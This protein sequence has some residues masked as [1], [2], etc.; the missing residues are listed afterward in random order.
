MEEIG[1]GSLRCWCVGS[2][3][4]V[5]WVLVQLACSAQQ[6][7]DVPRR[8]YCHNCFGTKL[9]KY[10]K[11][12]MNYSFFKL[13]NEYSSKKCLQ[14]QKPIAKNLSIRK[15]WQCVFWAQFITSEFSQL[16]VK[17]LMLHHLG[18]IYISSQREIS[19]CK[20]SGKRPLLKFPSFSIHFRGNLEGWLRLGTKLKIN[21]VIEKIQLIAPS[22]WF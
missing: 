14:L 2:P 7:D 15:V 17:D 5:V 16:Q 4:R 6:I 22:V 18:S 19:H 13:K 12:R 3:W 9:G 10:S 11:N 1:N 8:A 21:L 20:A